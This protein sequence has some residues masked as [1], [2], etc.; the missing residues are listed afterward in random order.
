MQDCSDDSIIYHLF[1]HKYMIVQSLQTTTRKTSIKR[2]VPNK[3][4]DLLECLECARF[5]EQP[6]SYTWIHEVQSCQEY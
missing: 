1:T 2:R 6:I 4:R 3:R 5:C